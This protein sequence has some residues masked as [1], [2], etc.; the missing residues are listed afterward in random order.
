VPNLK[1]L[2]SVTFTI[3]LGVIVRTRDCIMASKQS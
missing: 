1:T 3:M 2:L